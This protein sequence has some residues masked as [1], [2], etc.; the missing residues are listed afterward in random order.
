MLQHFLDTYGYLRIYFFLWLTDR[1]LLLLESIHCNKYS[2]IVDNSSKHCVRPITNWKNIDYQLVQQ[3]YKCYPCILDRYSLTM[4]IWMIVPILTV[5][6]AYVI[7]ENVCHPW[8]F[9]IGNLYSTQCF[10]FMHKIRVHAEPTVCSCHIHL[11]SGHHS[12]S[13]NI[14]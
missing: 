5:V 2:Y 14:P 4:I 9:K 10:N 8:S 3:S 6:D 7:G 11:V 12:L 1:I 13:S